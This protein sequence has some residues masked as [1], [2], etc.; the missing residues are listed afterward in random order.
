MS[1]TRKRTS[2]RISGDSDE[3]DYELNKGEGSGDDGDATSSRRSRADQLYYSPENPDLDADA[4][5]EE[6]IDVVEEDT[7]FL[8]QAIQPKGKPTPK[9]SK[10]K[11][12]AGSS[13]PRR[14][15]SG[16]AKRTVIYS[17]D[18]DEDDYD[19]EGER[20]DPDDGDYEIE[21]APKKVIIPG[22]SK[23]AA[24]RAV[25]AK[26]DKPITMKDERRAPA[27]AITTPATSSQ[28]TKRIR[29]KDEDDVKGGGPSTN[30]SD[31]TSSITG[32][33]PEPTPPIKKR[34]LPPI[35]KN[36]STTGS[37]AN[38]TPSTKPPVR[39]TP[40]KK[41][42]ISLIRKPAAPAANQDFDLRDA[43]VYAQLFT[44]VGLSVHS[45]RKC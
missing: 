8:P 11:S 4:E 2:K 3:D 1:S 37:T 38:S 45:L 39:P 31:G 25:K 6:D 12:R 27:S 30:V 17:D 43:S 7:R 23:G 21:P 13:V 9:S 15:S 19:A 20:V 14:R 29:A 35:K 41:D 32:K 36:K 18:E 16:K 40:E 42:D 33:E 34:K 5:G 24:G 10:S 22:K 44:K 28:G 26:L